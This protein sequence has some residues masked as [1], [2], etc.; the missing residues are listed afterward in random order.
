M[1][2]K[3]SIFSDFTVQHLSTLRLTLVFLD[4]SFQGMILL[5][6]NIIVLGIQIYT[7]LAFKLADAVHKYYLSIAASSIIVAFL[8]AV[9]AAIVA[10]L[11]PKVKDKSK[12]I[13][14]LYDPLLTM[15]YVAPKLD[16]LQVSLCS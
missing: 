14:Y 12:P 1:V 9:I 7:G 4:F 13:V 8:M 5:V 11:D 6:M 3:T 16:L 15:T 10:A 2:N